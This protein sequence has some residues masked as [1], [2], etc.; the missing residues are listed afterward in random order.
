MRKRN[1]V[2]VAAVLFVLHLLAT[3]AFASQVSPCEDARRAAVENILDDEGLLDDLNDESRSA[4]IGWAFS[5]LDDY[6][7]R[8][9]AAVGM[10]AF[11]LRVKEGMRV[12]AL[13]ADSATSQRVS[14]L[15]RARL[16]SW[17]QLHALKKLRLSIDTAD[18]NACAIMATLTANSTTT[19]DAP[20]RCRPS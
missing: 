4:I 14:W 11:G 3:P 15:Y 1:K 7:M 18:Q 17:R 5:R 8:C 20:Q 13:M 12:I 2:P 19:P 10:R 9:A 6:A 16:I